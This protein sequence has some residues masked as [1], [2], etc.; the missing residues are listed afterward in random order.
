L[1]RQRR[2]SIEALAFAADLHPTYLAG[3]ELGKRNPSWLK[4]CGVA[5]ALNVSMSDV[6]G[7]AERGGSS[8]V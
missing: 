4:L 3:I 5:E 8:Q 2:L 1:R 7:E 6:V